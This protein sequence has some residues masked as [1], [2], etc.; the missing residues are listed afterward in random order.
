M[1][2]NLIPDPRFK[3][4]ERLTANEATIMPKIE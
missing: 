2:V 1:T 4:T 3:H